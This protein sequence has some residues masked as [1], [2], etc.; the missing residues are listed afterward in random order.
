MPVDYSQSVREVYVKVVEYILHSDL[1][2]DVICGAF[3]KENKY[4]LPT[5][6]PSWSEGDFALIPM[7]FNRAKFSASRSRP[8]EAK[9]VRG[10]HDILRTRGFRVAT[11]SALGEPTGIT[12]MED[13]SL[14]RKTVEAVLRWYPLSFSYGSGELDEAFV[15]KIVCENYDPGIF[16]E[17]SVLMILAGIAWYSR[18]I[19]PEVGIHQRLLSFPNLPVCSEGWVAAW[20]RII[21]RIICGRRL[22][23]SSQGSIG[24]CPEK[25]HDGDLIVILLG[26]AIPVLLRPYNGI[27]S[28]LGMSIC[29]VICT[30]EA[31]MSWRRGNSSLRL[32]RSAKA[33]SIDSSMWSKLSSP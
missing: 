1:K 3:S 32:L 23:L 7:M 30:E 19:M 27:T 13:E 9:I 12:G 33:R 17:A 25:Y 15:K 8:P 18:Q 14:G 11:V 4:Q 5:W 28:W 21:H 24:L 10:E 26:C 6:A 20:V 16:D 31:L 22:F 2:L 29:M